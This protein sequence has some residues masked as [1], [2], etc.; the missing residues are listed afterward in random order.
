M[1]ESPVAQTQAGRLRGAI[2]ERGVA[3]FRGVP[4]AADTGGANR[5]RPPQPPEAWAG[6]R[7]ALQPGPIAPQNEPEFNL[8][9]L[10]PMSEDCLNLN[11]FTPGLDGKARPVLFYIHAGAFVSGAGSG[12]TQSGALLAAEQDVVV[13]TINYRLGVLGFPPFRVHGDAVSNNLG[14]LDQIAALEWV[15][16]NIAAFGG[17]PGN[18]TLFGYSAGG[19]SILSLMAAKG[20]RGLF[21]RA[22]PQ[23]G[24]EFGAMNRSGQRSLA[25]AYLEV[26]GVDDAAACLTLPLKDLLAAQQTIIERQQNDPARQT[27][28]TVNFGPAIDC[29][30]WAALP[31]DILRAGYAAPVPLLIGTTEDELGFAPFR[32]GIPWL[33][34]MHTLEAIIRSLT[35]AFGEAKAAMIWAAYETT[36]PDEGEERLAGRVRSDR[37]YRVPAIRAAELVARDRPGTGWMY[38]FDMKATSPVA[39]NVSTHATDLAFWFGTMADSPLQPFMFGRAPT[40][41]EE[42][43]SRAMRAD[44][45]SF[46]RDGV[47]AWKPYD[48]QARTTRLYAP[49]ATTA[50]DPAG[51]TRA[52]WDGLI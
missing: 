49:G 12:A 23:S 1:S 4:Y 51:A 42:A 48:A 15:K 44:L 40:P 34:A 26:L 3:I 38:R 14:L 27:E 45:A 11:V 18:V 2:D 32:G 36:Y 43:T 16:A 28:E 33:K 5:F 17:D 47:C 24:S 41:E 6:V 25:A 50:D 8:S 9:S 7:D 22:A 19:W 39:G 13:V 37:Y 46:A 31:M 29:G 30:D 35:A 20:A 52:A 21:H 10:P